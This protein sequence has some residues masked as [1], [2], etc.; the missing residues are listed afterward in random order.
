MSSKSSRRSSTLQ[1]YV[2]E[3]SRRSSYIDENNYNGGYISNI[4]SEID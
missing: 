4:N 1:K 2:E 3:S